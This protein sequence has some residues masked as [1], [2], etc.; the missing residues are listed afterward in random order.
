MGRAGLALGG[1]LALA[2]CSSGGGGTA[3]PTAS[4][5]TSTPA[6]FGTSLNQALEPLGTGLG[7]VSAAKDTVELNAA[8]GNVGSNAARAARTLKATTA[9][10][11]AEPG[12][13]DLLAALDALNEETSAITAV[14]SKNLC[15][16]AAGQ[17]KLTGGKGLPG[18][19][20]ALAKLDTAGVRS[21]FTVPKLAQKPAQPRTLENGTL[22]RDGGKGGK[23]TLKVKNTGETDAVVSL[24][25]DGA[26]VVSVYAAK[27]QEASVDGIKDGTYDAY[28]S[29]GTDWDP[30]AKLF[31]QGCKFSRFQ[32]KQDYDSKGSGTVWTVTT[33]TTD[34]EGSKSDTLNVASAPQP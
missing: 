16:V 29:T 7:K 11:E 14:G 25:V 27:G 26:S 20:A 4:A 15:G 6:A 18:L 24:A 2:A 17:M 34:G 5:S 1:V 31:T 28:V 10:A 12:R 33:K 21:T 13:T 22:V 8:L 23:G 19:T 30:D 32:D 9:P 3:A